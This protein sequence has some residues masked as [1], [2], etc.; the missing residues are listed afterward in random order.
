MRTFAQSKGITACCI[1]TSDPA[2][3]AAT[4]PVCCGGEEVW[5]AQARFLPGSLAHAVLREAWQ[6]A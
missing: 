6:A 1:L 5:L 2:R 3:R 4:A